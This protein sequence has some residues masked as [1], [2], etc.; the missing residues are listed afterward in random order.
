M[1]YISAHSTDPLTKT[2]QSIYNTYY[3]HDP[4]PYI[5]TDKDAN[6]RLRGDFNL[7]Y[8]H[9]EEEAAILN[10]SNSSTSN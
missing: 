5:Q 10:S 1:T 9:W 2:T 6:Q 4:L 7:T 3:T 8:V